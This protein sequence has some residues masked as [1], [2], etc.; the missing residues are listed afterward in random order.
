MTPPATHATCI[1]PKRPGVPSLPGNPR[2]P[3]RR[4]ANETCYSLSFPSFSSRGRR[5]ANPRRSPQCT[6]GSRRQYARRCRLR[7][8][9]RGTGR[10]F[11]VP[12]RFRLGARLPS[13]QH[14]LRHAPEFETRGPRQ[15]DHR[16]DEAADAR[17]GD[18]RY[19]RRLPL[20]GQHRGHGQL[21]R[22]RAQPHRRRGG[23]GPV[24]SPAG[25]PHPRHGR[26]WHERTGRQHRLGQLHDEQQHSL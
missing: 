8:E 14:A 24:E 15:L 13:A 16:R 21:H 23:P 9:G 18:A 17:S 12:S 22:I 2:T 3:P 1:Y 4:H 25:E 7:R 19:Q 11:T 10:A 26:C 6:N 5:V 20:R